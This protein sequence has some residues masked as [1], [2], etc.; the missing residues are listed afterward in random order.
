[1][2]NITVCFNSLAFTAVLCKIRP[3]SSGSNKGANGEL[4]ER[5]NAIVNN[6]DRSRF[7]SPFAFKKIKITTAVG[8]YFFLIPVNFHVRQSYEAQE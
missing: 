8:R 1:M 2:R 6:L 4:L 3:L 7:G 5:T